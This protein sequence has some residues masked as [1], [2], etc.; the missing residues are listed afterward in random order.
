[1]QRLVNEGHELAC[2][3]DQHRD[4]ATLS[5][6]EADTEL[7]ESLR[8]LREFAPVTSFRAPYLRFPTE[9][10]P[11]LVAY[12]V[13]VDSSAARYKFGV[14]HGIK[15]SV[16]D[17]I[18]IPASVTSSVLRLPNAVRAPWI[19]MAKKPLVLFVHPW[20]AVDFRR[21]QLRW[22]CRFRT[23]RVGLERWRD[24]IADLQQSG[25]AFVPLH[26]LARVAA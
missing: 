7:R 13:R 24:V 18:R 6:H 2:H 21:S 15:N 5:H 25:T 10:L 12:G 19:T 26:E 14:A 23:G 22:D 4:F 17:L 16:P 1:V 3:G 20:E 11:L 9:F 8:T